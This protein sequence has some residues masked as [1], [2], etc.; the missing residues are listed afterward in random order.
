VE[1]P[2]LEMLEKGVGVET[3]VRVGVWICVWTGV[4]SSLHR[5]EGTCRRVIQR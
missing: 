2:A 4:G 3:E 5:D 1:Y